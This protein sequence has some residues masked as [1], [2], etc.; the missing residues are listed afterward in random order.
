MKILTGVE[1]LLE[2]LDEWQPYAS[3]NLNSCHEEITSIK[4]LIIRYRKI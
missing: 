1:L 2:K 3:K 4:Q